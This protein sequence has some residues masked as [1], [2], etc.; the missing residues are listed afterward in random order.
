MNRL[1]WKLLGVNILVIAVVILIVW[2]A[3]DYLASDYFMALMKEYKISPTEVHRM[4]LDATHRSLIWASLGTLILATVLSFVLTRKL[5]NPLSQMAEI[6]ERIAAGDY[7]ARVHI[8]ST[9][10]FGQLG[11]AFNRM[12]DSLRRTEQLRKNLLIDV[13]HELR[14]PLT[15]IRGYLEAM[16]EGLVAP[17]SETIASLHEET[18][19]LAN[20]VEDLL[21]LARAEASTG[22]LRPENVDVRDLSARVLELFRPKFAAKGIQVKTDFSGLKNPVRADPE[23][24]TRVLRN[25]LENAWQYT[26]RGGDVRVCAVGLPTDIKMVFSNTGRGIAREDLPYIF[27]RFYRGEKSRSREHGGAGIGLTIV[28]EL[29]EAHGGKVG[30]DTSPKEVSIWFTLPS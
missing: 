14:T 28:K 15:N 12:A 2:L 25:L 5:L 6:T 17:T 23:K 13:A 29:I 21:Q 4:F 8:L 27:E 18:I 26:P 3:I 22:E 19:R 10:E 7:S 16:R 30:A 20:L 9:D 1:L 24:L 11:T